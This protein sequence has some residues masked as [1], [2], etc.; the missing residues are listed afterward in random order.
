MTIT[1]SQLFKLCCLA[2]YIMKQET[3]DGFMVFN[4]TFNNISALMLW[5]RIPIRARCTTL[6]DKVCQWLAAGQWF[7]LGSP[8][9]STNKTDRHD[10]SEILLKVSLNT[11][12]PTNV[13][14]FIIYIAKQH[15]LNS[16]LTVN[17]WP[18]ASH[19]Q[20]LSHNVVHLALIGIRS[21]NISCDGHWL[22]R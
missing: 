15:S 1:V 4:D 20:T 13:S 10:I 7:S 22:H 19:W 16:W 2:I 18:A 8:V 6:C 21:H 9:S 5:L 14:C 17:H 11:I 12:K 3:L